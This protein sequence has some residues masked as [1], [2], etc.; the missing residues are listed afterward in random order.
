MTLE[1][2]LLGVAHVPFMEVLH[3]SERGV[4]VP[5]IHVP[6]KVSGGDS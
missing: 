6:A 4:V 3:P 1:D 2:T 5:V